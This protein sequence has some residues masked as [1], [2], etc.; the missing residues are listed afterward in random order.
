MVTKDLS[1]DVI[2]GQ[3]YQRLVVL[4]QEL[5]R[6]QTVSREQETPEPPK[7]TFASLCGVWAGVDLSQD[8][9]AKSHIRLPEL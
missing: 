8:E 9:I 2:L 5:A 1:T 3:F 4:E 6:L 7:M